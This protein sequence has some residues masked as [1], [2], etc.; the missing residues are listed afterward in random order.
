[1]MTV[2]QK[3]VKAAQQIAGDDNHGYD[4]RPGYRLGSPDYACS[5]YVAACYRNAG[6]PVPEDSYTA[7]MLK[8]W[9]PHGFKN[10]AGKVDLRTGM[11]IRAGDVVIAP[12]KHTAIC[13]NSIT[14]RLAE[15]AGN[16]RGGPENGRTGDQGREIRLRSWYDDGWSVCLRYCG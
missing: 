12:G 7:T 8:T 1:M 16:P 15:A 6:I 3:A 10:V 13:I 4:N 11:G 5:S 2:Q 14:H 9:K